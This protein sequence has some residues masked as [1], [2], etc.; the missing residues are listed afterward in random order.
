VESFYALCISITTKI[1][2]AIAGERRPEVGMSK[3]V[4]FLNDKEV[5]HRFID[6]PEQDDGNAGA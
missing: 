1:I 3:V 4:S 5:D 2:R 6:Y